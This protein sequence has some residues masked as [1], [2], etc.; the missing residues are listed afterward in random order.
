[1]YHNV[2]SF[3]PGSRPEHLQLYFYDDDPNLNHRA[4]STENLDQSVIKMLV[5]ILKENPYSEQFRRLGAQ[6]ENLDEYRIELNT[7]QKLDQR[8]YNK[9]IADEVAA[10]WVEG[11]NLARRFERSII[12]HGNNNERYGIQATQGCYDPLSYPLFFPNAELGWHPN[13][14][15]QNVSYA[16]VQKSRAERDNDAGKIF[17][18]LIYFVQFIPT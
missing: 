8:R 7:D 4:K 3:R 18:I 17:H 15:K 10:I 13:I 1:M 11:N 14:P 5:D 6:K 2:H 16:D 12:L 9:P